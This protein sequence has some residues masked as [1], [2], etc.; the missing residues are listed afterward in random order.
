M[1]RFEMALALRFTCQGYDACF[2]LGDM[3]LGSL[4]L[5]NA[6]LGTSHMLSS[7]SVL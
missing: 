6:A 7:L 4:Q 2:W 1:T 5:Q 3:H